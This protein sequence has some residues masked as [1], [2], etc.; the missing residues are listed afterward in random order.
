[1]LKQACQGFGDGCK[2]LLR[3]SRAARGTKAPVCDSA[4]GGVPISL[5]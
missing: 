2:C 5:F 4:G 1:M 3:P